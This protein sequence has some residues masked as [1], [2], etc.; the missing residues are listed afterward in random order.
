M[1]PL[2]SAL[3]NSYPLHPK[4]SPENTYFNFANQSCF[5]VNVLSLCDGA[6]S[7]Q[8]IPTPLFFARFG[9]GI[10]KS[11]KISDVLFLRAERCF[12]HLR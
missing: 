11:T 7:H 6:L 4:G 2:S 1:E 10:S 9:A 8:L 3:A 12:I 5:I